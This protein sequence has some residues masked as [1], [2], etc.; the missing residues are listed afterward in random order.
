M[1]SV[2]Q[3]QLW[4]TDETFHSIPLDLQQSPSTTQ[5]PPI[6]M[7]C[8]GMHR[9]DQQGLQRP[10]SSEEPRSS[11]TRGAGACENLR[12]WDRT[13]RT[14]TGFLTGN[15]WTDDEEDAGSDVDTESTASESDGSPNSVTYYQSRPANPRCRSAN[16]SSTSSSSVA[17]RRSSSTGGPSPALEDQQGMMLPGR[18]GS[19]EGPSRSPSKNIMKPQ[20]RQDSFT[21]TVDGP[22]AHTSGSTTATTRRRSSNIP[23]QRGSTT[24]NNKYDPEYHAEQ[25]LLVHLQQHY[26]M[27]TWDM[28]HRITQ[29]RIH[30]HHTG[31]NNKTKSPAK[32][33]SID[34]CLLQST[35]NGRTCSWSSS[36]A[37]PSLRPAVQPTSSPEP[38]MDNMLEQ[39]MIFPLDD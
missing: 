32:A 24:M 21:A 3:V 25:A 26:A 34:H 19:R 16:M 8:K 15:T 5:T 31:S 22:R 4:S 9:Y 1:V 38:A 14:G 11:L 18:K 12:F 35:S 36:S 2:V 20:Q 28:Y 37:S 13:A 30:H 33:A 23:I 10:G 7:A 17:A 39:E 6:T 27:R 29:S